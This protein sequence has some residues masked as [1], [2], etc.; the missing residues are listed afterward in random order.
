[1]LYTKY[2]IFSN[3]QII[4]RNFA[5][6]TILPRKKFL[7]VSIKISYLMSFLSAAKT[8]HKEASHDEYGKTLMDARSGADWTVQHD[9]AVCT[10][11]ARFI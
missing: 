1:M 11:K 4:N 9:G 2:D 10:A 3:V 5:E 8:S 7:I 6:P